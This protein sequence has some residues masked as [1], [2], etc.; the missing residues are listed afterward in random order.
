[1]IINPIRYAELQ[2]AFNRTWG[3]KVP[4]FILSLAELNVHGLPNSPNCWV[5]KYCPIFEFEDQYKE[6]IK[7]LIEQPESKIDNCIWLVY[8]RPMGDC[9]LRLKI[10]AVLPTKLHTTKTQIQAWLS[11][12]D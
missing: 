8:E 10:E 6:A 1:M 12:E 9:T 3:S 7:W 2:D 4:E 11:E 5:W